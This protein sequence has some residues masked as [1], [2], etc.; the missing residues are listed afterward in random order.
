MNWNKNSRKELKQK[1]RLEIPNEVLMEGLILT[2]L[3]IHES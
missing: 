1:Y 2:T 3:Q